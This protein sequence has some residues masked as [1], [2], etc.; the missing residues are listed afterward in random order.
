VELYWL[1][2]ILILNI[3]ILILYRL[4]KHILNKK[5]IAKQ[6]KYL[7]TFLYVPLIVIIIRISVF[8]I[9]KIPSTSL[10]NTLQPGNLVYVN[11]LIFDSILPR[12]GYKIPW[13]NILWYL[14]PKT[15]K[16]FGKNVWLYYC[17]SGYCKIKHNDLMVFKSSKNNSIIYL[18]KRCIGLARDN[19]RIINRQ[20][21]C[22][23]E[24]ITLSK[25]VKTEYKLYRNDYKA[26]KNLKVWDIIDN[27]S[28]FLNDNTNSVSVLTTQIELNKLNNCDYIGSVKQVVYRFDASD[29]TSWHVFPYNKKQQ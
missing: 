23:G 21:Y 18:I 3:L 16:D 29:Y 11:K 14:N 27:S 4:K 24:K 12:S 26:L 15:R 25:T 6:L 10:A 7:L 17:L 8:G 5:A 1:G 20:V 13:L 22:N 28:F 19:I 9:Y 2:I